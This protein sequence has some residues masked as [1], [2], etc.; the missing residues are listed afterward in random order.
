MFVKRKFVIEHGFRG[1]HGYA[2]ICKKY[3]RVNPRDRVIR[4]LYLYKKWKYDQWKLLL[5]ENCSCVNIFIQPS[6]QNIFSLIQS[7]CKYMFFLQF[8]HLTSIISIFYYSLSFLRNWKWSHVFYI[9]NE[10]FFSI[11]KLIKFSIH[12]FIV[13]P[14]RAIWAGCARSHHSTALHCIL[15]WI[16]L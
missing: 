12:L 11:M 6:V 3:I 15:P 2:R 16:P 13:T 9:L 4:V 14:F 10:I 8:A 5:S 1:W 7:F